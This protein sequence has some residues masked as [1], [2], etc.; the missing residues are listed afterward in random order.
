MLLK[1]EEPLDLNNQASWVRAR[2]YANQIGTLPNVFAA[3]VRLLLSDHFK[4]QGNLRPVTKYLVSQALRGKKILSMFYYAT[5]KLKAEQ[6]AAKDSVKMGELVALYEPYDVAVIYGTFLIYRRARKVL[7]YNADQFAALI[8]DFRRDS[9]LG[10]LVG[11]AI[12]KIGIGNGVLAGSLHPLALGLM[13]S[14]SPQEVNEYCITMKGCERKLDLELEMKLFGCTV[15]QTAAVLLTKVGFNK[16]VVE[17]YVGGIDP[18]LRMGQSEEYD[19]IRYARLWIEGLIDKKA[20]PLES[21]PGDYYPLAAAREAMETQVHRSNSEISWFER[22]P[23]HISEELT[24]KLFSKESI[25]KD[26]P[27]QLRDIFTLK[28]ITA[29]PEEEFDTLIDE[30]DKNIRDGTLEEHLSGNKALFDK[31]A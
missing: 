6:L 5:A 27:Q 3:A 2:Q 31:E 15:F 23:E 13:A 10:G 16:A 30:I 22:E 20:Q 25:Q 26:V 4:H 9:Q 19:Q 12:P 18:L 14:K 24:P 1:P 29:M 8:P 11:A 21:M 7:E 17:S 28:E